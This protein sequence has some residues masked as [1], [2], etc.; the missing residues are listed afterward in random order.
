MRRSTTSLLGAAVLVLAA[1]GAPSPTEKATPSA[2][3]HQ[4]AI[5][6]GPGSATPSV[7]VPE[8]I[9]GVAAVEVVGRADVATGL[10]APWA[11]VFAPDGTM[12]VSE[13]DTGRLIRVST[14]GAVTPLTGPGADDIADANDATGEAGLLGLAL[15]P[16][17]PSLLYAYQTRPDGNAV[18]RMSLDGDV[19]SVPT[20][21]LSGIPKARNHDGG[22]LAFGPD[23]Y[24]YVA[25]GDAA[26]PDSAQDPDSLA[27]AI[28]RV[29]A[30]GGPEDGQ[31]AP[32]NPFGTEVY[33]YG[34]RNVQGLGFAPDGRLF[35]SEFGQSDAD[36]LNLIAPGANYG[37]PTVEGLLGAPDGTDLGQTVEG[38]TYPVVQWT[39]TSVASP[40]GIAVTREAVY[41][42]TL[43]GE[44][45]YRVGLTGAGVREPQV[46]LDDLGRLRD[47]V[48]GPDGA[49]YVLTNNTDGRGTPRAGD[50]RIVR[51]EIAP[52]G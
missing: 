22:G 24:L 18:L 35:A 29:V 39:P 25:T 51:V 37:W 12:I 3:D 20:L 44:T 36:E 52:A 23:G 32:E 28:L 5:S 13:R 45:L 41:V 9:G 7:D 1:C 19:L 26:R 2:D 33:S 40:S 15:H 10:D 11:L 38:L 50:D 16:D 17:D 21:V 49:L 43:R 4:P 6:A 47:V 48:V 8:V 42:A 34:H 27:G 30:T 14:D 46:V 31:A